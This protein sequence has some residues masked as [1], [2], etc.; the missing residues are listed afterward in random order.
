VTIPGLTNGGGTQHWCVIASAETGSD[1]AQV[2]PHSCTGTGGA[3]TFVLKNT[4]GGTICR[5]TRT[6][7]INA[8]FV[9]NAEPATLKMEGEPEFTKEETSG[10]LCSGTG[11]IKSLNFTLETDEPPYHPLTIS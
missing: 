11:K 4:P 6:A 1:K 8:T 10:F 2:V 5:Y 9:T 3:F 7:S